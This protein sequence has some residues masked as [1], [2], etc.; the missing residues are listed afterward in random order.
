MYRERVLICLFILSVLFI[1]PV[2]TTAQGT[3]GD[4]VPLPAFSAAYVLSPNATVY[5]GTTHLNVSERN[6]VV[7]L[8]ANRT[9]Y[10]QM[11]WKNS[12]TGLGGGYTFAIQPNT[13]YRYILGGL[14]VSNYNVSV[15][16]SLYVTEGY[17]RIYTVSSLWEAVPIE[18]VTMIVNVTNTVTVTEYVTVEVASMIPYVFSGILSAVVIVILINVII[19]KRKSGEWDG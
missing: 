15:K 10:Y 18:V 4:I 3:D 12:T 9:V 17:F 1:S 19:L 2:T 16:I 11:L 8:Y 6:Y 14:H 13:V 5:L 7:E